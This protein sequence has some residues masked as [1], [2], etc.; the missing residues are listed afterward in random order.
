[1]N[2][3]GTI[4]ALFRCEFP[5]LVRSLSVAFGPEPAADAVQEAFIAADRRWGRVGAYSDPAGWVRRVALNRLLNE[6][7]LQ[8]RRDVILD[9]LQPPATVELS[10]EALDLAAAITML[11][12]QQRVAVC[13]RYLGDYSIDEV[14]QSMDL[15]PGTVK[16]HLH[17][18]RASLRLTLTEVEP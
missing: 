7:R 1:M 2:E 13:L 14:A 16:A 6:R 17:A 8:R 18:A 11:P 4:E 12:T 5:R 15:A 9:G 3:Q 10:V